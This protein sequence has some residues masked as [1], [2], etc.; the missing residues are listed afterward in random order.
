MTFGTKLR[1]APS[2]V[3]QKRSTKYFQVTLYEIQKESPATYLANTNMS[4]QHW[5]AFFCVNNTIECFDSFGRNPAEYSE[6]LAAG[7]N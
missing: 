2:T 6:H 5:F 3:V 7:I 4:G 1:S